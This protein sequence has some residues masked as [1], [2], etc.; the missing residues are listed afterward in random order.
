[1]STTGSGNFLTRLA[2]A[3]SDSVACILPQQSQ[4]I[5]T[6]KNVTRPNAVVLLNAHGNYPLSLFEDDEDGQVF[7]RTFKEKKYQDYTIGNKIPNMLLPSDLL[8]DDAISTLFN[9]IHYTSSVP[10]PYCGMM[11]GETVDEDGKLIKSSR[12]SEFDIVTSFVSR[13]QARTNNDPTERPQSIFKSMRGALRDNANVMY[14]TNPSEAKASD[15]KDFLM[16][17]NSLIN[18]NGLYKE[19]GLCTTNFDKT[20]QFYPNNGENPDFIPHYGF[21]IWIN[22]KYYNLL[23]LQDCDNILTEVIFYIPIDNPKRPFAVYM[24]NNVIKKGML[25]QKPTLKLSEISLFLW[26]LDLNDIFISDSACSI[27]LDMQG[28]DIVTNDNFKNTIGKLYSELFPQIEDSQPMDY[29]SDID[30]R[31]TPKLGSK[32]KTKKLPKTKEEIQNYRKETMQKILDAKKMR[33][34]KGDQELLG[35]KSTKKTKMTKMKKT[36]KVTRGK[37]RNKTQM[38]KTKKR[39]QTKRK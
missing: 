36:T 2:D 37:R 33:K 1:M 15:I 32:P 13:L 21:H 19:Y 5:Y 7:T 23:T 8:Y 12:Q 27:V 38:K 34:K 24:L 28:D 25:Q 26:S 39:K 18:S 30:Y 20:Y 10:A 17:I 4:P 6:R 35:G 11:V 3:I 14:K 9:N 16:Y 31:V 29:E 22:D